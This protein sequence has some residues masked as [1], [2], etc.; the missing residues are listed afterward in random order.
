M[1][2]SKYKVL[3]L[4]HLPVLAGQ[5]SISVFQES[6]WWWGGGVEREREREREKRERERLVIWCC[7]CQGTSCQFKD[8]LVIFVGKQ[9]AFGQSPFI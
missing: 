3:L 6:S 1:P 2:C 8:V 9:T 7:L 5:R 4:I